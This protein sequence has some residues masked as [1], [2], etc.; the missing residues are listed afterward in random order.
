MICP[1]F[2]LY[3]NNFF[4]KCTQEESDCMAIIEKC[5]N[6]LGRIVYLQDRGEENEKFN[7]ISKRI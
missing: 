7:R 6:K 3:H 1:Y 5:E 2:Y 4:C